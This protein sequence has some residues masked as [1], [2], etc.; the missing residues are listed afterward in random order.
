MKGI[1]SYTNPF[2][3]LLTFDLSDKL[4]DLKFLDG[5]SFN[6][7]SSYIIS[8]LLPPLDMFKFSI[9]DIEL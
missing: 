9:C 2:F 1:F 6:N 5:P 8:Y 4:I 7:C 3:L